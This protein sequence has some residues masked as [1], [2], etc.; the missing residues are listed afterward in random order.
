MGISIL[1]MVL[2]QLR[3]ANI[4]ADLAFPGQQFPDITQTVAAVHLE[5]MD[6]PNLTV[7][8]GVTLVGPASAG[9]TACELEALRAAEVLR[10]TGAKCVQNGCR[11]DGMAQVY[12]VELFAAFVGVTEA[13]SYQIGPGFQV[14]IGQAKLSYVQ[15][16]EALL[17]Q[18][19]QAEYAMG[20][21]LPVGFSRKQ[22]LWKITLR[23]LVPAGTQEQQETASPFSLTVFRN[24]I[25]EVYQ[26]CRWT[27]VRRE[28]SREGLLKIRTGIATQRKEV[29]G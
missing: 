20:E 1:E 2:Q 4:K 18:D 24:G 27:S 12:L 22:D 6:R 16:F 23:E 9:G 17:Q 11:F 19:Y 25:T 28:Q 7:T 8:V 13:D 3:K 10:Q 5:K 26:N 14:R 21:E 15:S 29:R